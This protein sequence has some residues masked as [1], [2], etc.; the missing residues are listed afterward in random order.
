MTTDLPSRARVVIVGG[1]VIGT[2]TAYHLTRLGWTDVLLLE[3][4]RLSGGT[5]WHA[6][7]LVGPLRASE[8]GTRLVQYS[9]ELYARL[10]AETGLATGYKQRR[11]RDRGPHRGPD[12]AAA[13]DRGQRRRRTTWSARCS[14]PSEALE[15]WPV[16]RG[17]RPA[18]RDLAARRRQGQPDR[19]D[20]GAGQGRPAA[21]RPVVERARVARTCSPADG[22]GDRGPAP[23]A[24]DVEAEVVVNCAGQWAKALGATGRRHGAAALGRALLRRDRRRSRACTR[25]CRSCATRT[26]GP[27][28]RRRSA[29]WWSAAS[30]P[31]PSRG[32]R[33]TRSPLP[34]RVPAA[35]RGLGALLGADGRGAC[36]GSRRWPRPGSASSTTV[37]SRS[38]PTTSSCWARRPDVRGFFVGAGFNSVGIASA[39]GAGRALAEWVVE[40]EPTTRPG[41]RS[42]SAGSRPST[43]TT[44]WLR[45]AG[46]GGARAALRRAVA[47][48]RAGDRPA[49]PAA[50]R[51]TTG[52][53]RPG[54]V[55]RLQDGLGAAQ[56]LRAGRR[57]RRARRTPGASRPG[58]RWSA[59]EQRATREAVAVFDQT[60]FSKYV[61]AGP[62]RSRRLQW[63][64][65]A[66]VDVPVGRCVYTPL[67]NARGTYE[68]DL[69]VTRVG[70]DEFLLV[71]SSATTVRDLDW[72]RRHVPA[73]ST[74]GSAT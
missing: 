20:H 34:V 59:A 72:L 74:P 38:R 21:R 47:E 24:G 44:G 25:T 52:W 36:A 28:S 56:R 53:P 2:S 41:R 15:R 17:R 16:M 19:P 55:L 3:Q 12:G 50:R 23:T 6:A 70:A 11:R 71:S 62:R 13:P 4:G 67:L 49:V 40:G 35:R 73:G 31:R 66:D 57:R 54:R 46:R 48:P 42:T 26:A 33:R 68:A 63:V 45:V 39:G 5:T 7:G 64:C 1:G 18:R 22:A 14:R 58:C 9:A 29:A 32:G 30:S 8:S 61:V 43:A 37:P 69:T 60:S 65:A 51:C 27:T 10:E